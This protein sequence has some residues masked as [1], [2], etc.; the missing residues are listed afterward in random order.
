M[1]TL[2]SS[3]T[4]TANL[5]ATFSNDFIHLQLTEVARHSG[6]FV[7]WNIKYV[8]TLFL[9]VI[10]TFGLFMLINRTSVD[11]RIHGNGAKSLG[12]VSKGVKRPEPQVASR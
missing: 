4:K 11:V 2:V 6:R 3:I 1:L 10:E 9:V 12:A 8:G 7:E 5:T